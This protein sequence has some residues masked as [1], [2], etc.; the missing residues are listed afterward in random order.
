VSGGNIYAGTSLAGI[1]RSTNNGTNWAQTT[2]NN[3][4]IKS[5]V[6]IS[7]YIFAGSYSLINPTGIYRST[8]GG[9]WTSFGLS[10]INVLSLAVSGNNIFAGTD[11]GLYLSNNNGT[12]W[13]IKNQGFSTVPHMEAF[14]IAEN[15][16]FAGTQGE[17]IWRRSLMEVIGIKSI[18]TEI[19]SEYSLSQNY[20][21]PFN[22]STNIRYEIPKNGNVKIVVIDDL[23]R[24]VETLVNENQTAGTYETTFNASQYPSG[25]YLYRLIS[26]NFNETKKMILLK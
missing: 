9:I 19:P 24:E 1:Y 23:G 13:F 16:V 15:F 22:P 3:L 18:S 5:L 4:S 6:S 20:P 25:V 11:N 26:D 7:S 8:D 10:S 14:F 17:S 21:N 2:L 12:T